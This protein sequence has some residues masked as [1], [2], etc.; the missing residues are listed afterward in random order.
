MDNVN[1]WEDFRKREYDDAWAEYERLVEGD[2]APQD[3]TR[4]SERSRLISPAMAQAVESSVAEIEEA[5]FGRGTGT[6]FDVADDVADTDKEDM[7]LLRKIL[8]EDIEMAKMHQEM[9]KT[10]WNGAV[11]GTGISKLMPERVTEIVPVPVVDPKTGIGTTSTVTVERFQVKLQAINP[12]EF[13]IDPSARSIDEALGCAHIMIKPRHTITAKQ[14]DGVYKD[15]FLGSYSSGMGG[16]DIAETNLTEDQ[17][18]IVE[19]YGKIPARYLKNGDEEDYQEESLVE[20]DNMEMVEA[21]VTIGNDQVLLRAVES[22]M[23]MKDR[24][25]VA[26][27]HETVNDSFWGRSVCK[28]GYNP[29]KALDAELRARVDA[30]ALTVHPMVGINAT[31]LPRG[32]KAEV[33]PGKAWL[34]NGNPRE[35]MEPFTLGNINPNTFPQAA[36]M[37]RMIS[38]GTGAMDTAAPLS[39]NPRNQT[40]SGMSMMTSQ[41]V[42]RSKR[43]M[44]NIEEEYLTK[45]VH[46]TAHRYMQFDPSRYPVMD[47]KFKVVCGMGIMARELEQGQLTQLLSIIPPDS[48]VFGVILEGLFENSSLTNKTELKAALAQQLQ[49]PSPEQ[50]QQQQEAQELV[51]QAAVMDIRETESKVIKNLADAKAKGEQIDVSRMQAVTAATS[52]KE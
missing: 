26:Y 48:P 45:I 2:W 23:I 14:K 1:R 29:Q 19:Y 17:V 41:F 27:Q 35:A 30:M 6:W 39:T 4:D 15:K 13:V 52:T 10:F 42:K 46:K 38:M 43:N 24:P 49:G 11:Y 47:Y 36:D 3:K 51:K 16:D 37:E 8:R 22:P 5:V 44:R 20:T 9:R 7:G 34:F 40:A 28:K 21:I 31:M 25:I 50:L 32:F 33:R 18:K 12:K